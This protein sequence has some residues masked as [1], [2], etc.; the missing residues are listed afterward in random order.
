MYYAVCAVI[1]CKTFVGDIST[2][3]MTEYPDALF[4]ILL[5]KSFKHNIYFLATIK[6]VLECVRILVSNGNTSFA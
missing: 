1:D 4:H 2:E 5:L 3:F 6:F